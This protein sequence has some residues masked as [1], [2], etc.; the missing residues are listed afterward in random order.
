MLAGEVPLLWAKTTIPLKAAQ[1]QLRL[2]CK[3]GDKPLGKLLFT[4]PTLKRTSIKIY[5]LSNN[6]W[7]R[8]SWFLFAGASLFLEEC[9]LPAFLER[10]QNQ[11]PATS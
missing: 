6:M 10:L 5:P 4:E 1:R 8:S 11:K 2:V 3:L 9:F 7:G